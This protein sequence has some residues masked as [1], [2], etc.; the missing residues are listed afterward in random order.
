M[1][2]TT[3]IPAHTS[4]H[5]AWYLLAALTMVLGF[6]V[7]VLAGVVVLDDDASPARQG[8]AA[9]EATVSAS[10]APTMSADAAER[11]ATSG[12]EV[13]QRKASIEAAERQAEVAVSQAVAACQAGAGSPDAIERCVERALSPSRT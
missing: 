5:G 3:T 1:T 9:Q 6:A 7:G 8:S 10:A 2:A 12:T 13:Y 4:T 11:W